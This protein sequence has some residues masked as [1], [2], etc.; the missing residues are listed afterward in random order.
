MHMTSFGFVRHDKSEAAQALAE[1]SKGTEEAAWPP[2]PRLLVASF[3]GRSARAMDSETCQTADA[4][5][6]PSCGVLIEERCRGPEMT[7][8][9]LESESDSRGSY[10]PF[11]SYYILN[12]C[13]HDVRCSVSRAYFT[14]NA[15]TVHAASAAQSSRHISTHTSH[16]EKRLPD[17]SQRGASAADK[18][19]ADLL[20]DR[21]GR[22]DRGP[23]C[24]A[25]AQGGRRGRGI[26][27]GGC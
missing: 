4:C 20:G 14:H 1:E 23:E 17:P 3:G 11:D 16:C 8:Q 15:N 13:C 6:A 26:V 24:N 9:S 5:L 27:N 22:G 19:T 21:R 10:A 12:A 7:R 18:C 25:Q 2:R